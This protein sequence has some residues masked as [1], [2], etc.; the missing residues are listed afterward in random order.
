MPSSEVVPMRP[1]LLLSFL[2]ALLSTGCD[3]EKEEGSD[4][5]WLA[6]DDDGDGLA[7]GEE[8]E[9]GTDPASAD[10]DGDGYQDPWEVTE[11]SDPT[12]AEDVIYQGG[13]PYQPDKDSFEDADNT[14]EDTPWV[15]MKV[16]RIQGWDQYGDM[17]DLY[18]FAGIDRP[19]LIDISA[20]WCGPCKAMSAYI[21]GGADD[22]GWSEY[23]PSLPGLI[24]DGSIQWITFLAE[25]NSWGTP[26][27]DTVA[28]WDEYFPSEH[29]PVLADDGTYIETVLWFPTF[30]LI[31]QDMMIVSSEEWDDS[32]YLEP[33]FTLEEMYGE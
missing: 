16:P 29:I 14:V 9:I 28:N 33:L 21:T 13:W 11:G 17:V 31:D 7:N 23:F 15:G 10:S 32:R 22:Y 12:D 6:A 20:Y 1:S 5:A 25:N 30:I 3:G 4:E 18:D 27:E 19:L 26:D 2:S 24:E 8:E